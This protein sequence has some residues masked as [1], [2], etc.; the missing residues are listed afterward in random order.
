MGCVVN[1]P[2]EAKEADIGIA[3]GDGKGILFKKGRVVRKIDQDKLV[4]QL[5][6]EIDNMTE[7]SEESNG[8]KD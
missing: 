7:N 5:L 3:G 4:D 2:G 1:G 6:K 8:K